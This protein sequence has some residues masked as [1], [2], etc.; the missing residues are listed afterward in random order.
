MYELTFKLIA[1]YAIKFILISLTSITFIVCLFFLLECL[2]AVISKN[3]PVY[4][5][6]WQDTK[7]TVLIP[8]HNEEISIASTLKTIIPVLKK[9]D[10]VVVVADNCS[11]KTAEIA[12]SVGA[13]VI[14]R[15]HSTN[16]GKGYA[17]DYGLQYMEAEPPDVVIIIDA[18]CKV[19]Q[20]AIEQLTE[21]S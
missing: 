15:F 2:T 9:Q 16:K 12:S 13:T 19:E 6:K 21:C 1:L 14:E 8:A 5:G 18:D 10:D 3:F 20:G 7:I 11:D 4:K 17:L